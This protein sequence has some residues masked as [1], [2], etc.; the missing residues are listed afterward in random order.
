[1]SLGRVEHLYETQTQ[2]KNP[3]ETQ[4]DDLG[5]YDPLRAGRADCHYGF[6]ALNIGLRAAEVERRRVRKKPRAVVLEI[7]SRAR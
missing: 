7:L 2:S 3:G 1:V 5:C 4:F 6:G